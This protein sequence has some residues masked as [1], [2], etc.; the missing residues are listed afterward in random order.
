M[1]GFSDI[2]DRVY[3]MTAISNIVQEPSF[4][5]MYLIAFILLYILFS[6]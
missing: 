5:V 4:L 3:E 6:Q 1:T 2:L